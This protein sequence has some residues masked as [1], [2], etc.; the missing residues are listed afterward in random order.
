MMLDAC[1]GYHLCIP[2]YTYSC[3][4]YLCMYFEFGHCRYRK[5]D[6]LPVVPHVVLRGRV[7][8]FYTLEHIFNQSHLGI[9]S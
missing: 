6:M 8:I 3:M 1:L 5:N 4:A 9:S 7:A 2:R